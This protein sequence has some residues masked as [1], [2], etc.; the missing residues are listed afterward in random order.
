MT[1]K[2]KEKMR[3]TRVQARFLRWVEPSQR[4]LDAAVEKAVAAREAA[5]QAR[6]AQLR[7]IREYD[8][9]CREAFAWRAAAM[10]RP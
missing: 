7:A 1:T 6:R 8:E 5:K 3:V 9:V 2:A 4:K 10:G